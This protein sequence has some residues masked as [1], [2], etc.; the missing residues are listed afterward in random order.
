MGEGS[1]SFSQDDLDS[2]ERGYPALLDIAGGMPVGAAVYARGAVAGDIWMPDG[3]RLPLMETRVLGANVERLYDS[4]KRDGV[5]RPFSPFHD[6]QLLMFGEIGQARLSEARVGIIGAGGVGSLLVE[7][8]SRLGVGNLIVVDDDR[9]SL[10]N[11]S[12]VV[13]AS[14]WDARYPFSLK[15][16]PPLIRKFAQK[17]SVHKV[18]ISRRVALQANHKCNVETIIGDFSQ[19][20]IAARFLGCDFLFLAADSMRARLV[21]NAIV[22]QYYIPGIQIGTKITEGKESLTL[23]DA[24]SVER[25]VLPRENC[26][27]CSGFISPHLL[28]IE[29]KTPEERRDQDYG[30]RTPSPSVITMNATVSSLAVTDF[31][32]SF[33]CLH[34]EGVN[35]TPRRIKH[36]TRQIIEEHHPQNEECTECSVS[37]GSRL[38]KGDGESLPTLGTA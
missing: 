7:Y 35:V 30:A 14:R 27:W 38:G 36:C 28:A 29:A 37:L 19:A 9:V 4:P 15:S 5:E 24:F 2:H 32:M 8:L 26:L 11:L 16:A 34:A 13:G 21:F 6:R 18:N 17:H 22:Q 20:K 10:S 12:R 25:W 23:E 31:M 3:S 1:V 33:L